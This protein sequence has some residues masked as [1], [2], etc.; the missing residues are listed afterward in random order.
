MFNRNTLL[1]LTLVIPA[2]A[3]HAD[4]PQTTSAKIG[5]SIVQTINKHPFISSFIGST[6]L[7]VGLEAAFK[8]KNRDSLGSLGF[9]GWIFG[10]LATKSATEALMRNFDIDPIQ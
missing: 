8:P 4:K 2:T 5:H 7:T 10:G 9:L 6:L 3:I 1:A